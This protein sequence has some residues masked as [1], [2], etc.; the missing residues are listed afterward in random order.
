MREKK[1]EFGGPVGALL[2][3]VLLPAVVYYLYFCIR[4]NNGA[5]IPGESIN[6]APFGSFWKSIIPTGKAA[7]LYLAWFFFQV[8]LQLFIPGRIF[9]GAPLKDGTRLSYNM[10]GLA[11][12]L[13]TFAILGLLYM[14]GVIDFDTIYNNLGALISVVIIF[15]VLLSIFVYVYSRLSGQ[16][17]PESDNP[18][19]NFFL[20]VAL[21]PRIPPVKGFDLKIFCESRPGLIGWIVINFSFMGYQYMKHGEVSLAMILV[22]VF[23]FIYIADYFWYESAILSTRDILHDRFGSMLIFGDLAWVPFTYSLQAFYLID[24]VHTMPIWFACLVTILNLGGYYIFRNSNLQKHEFRNRPEKPIWGKKPEY[25][26]TGQGNK[27]LVSGFWGLSR[28]ANYFGDILM[29]L[30]WCLTCMFGSI[31]PYFYVI[32]FTILLVHRERRDNRHGLEKY[33][34]DWEKY[35]D[36]VK[37]RIIPYIY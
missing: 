17:D 7:I 33:G 23:Q 16:Y 14:R 26:Q 18:L 2:L 10:N 11:S 28:H 4:F 24:H 6:Y 15:S 21:N 36:M 13:I 12:F 25:I 19:Y 5:L 34:E 29:A 3:M 37:W 22:C 30:A 31:V 20:G 8:L 27:L 32:Y 9:E 1:Y 35:T